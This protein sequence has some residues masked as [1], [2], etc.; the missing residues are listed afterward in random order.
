V[1]VDDDDVACPCSPPLEYMDEDS[2]SPLL[3]EQ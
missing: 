3:L 2:P 1:I